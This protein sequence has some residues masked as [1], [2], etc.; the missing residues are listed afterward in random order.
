MVTGL[1]WR[2][3]RRGIAAAARKRRCIAAAAAAAAAHLL[4]E[5]ECSRA[6]AHVANLFEKCRDWKRRKKM[7]RKQSGDQYYIVFVCTSSIST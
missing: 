4:L 5:Q 7:E 1:A 2:R 6:F 3:K